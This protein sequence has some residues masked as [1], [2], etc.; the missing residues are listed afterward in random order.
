VSKPELPRT[1]R[2]PDGRIVEFNDWSWRHIMVERPQ[3]LGDVDA[4]LA[5]V[6]SPDYREDDPIAGRKRFYQ[7]RVTDKVR[8]L[9]V[10]V[11]F[12]RRPA[13]VVTA[14]IQRKNPARDQ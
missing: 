3:L 13:V 7:R 10:V 5:A 12:N 2:D 9:R 14:F 1:A 6:A 8:W 11:D 4:V